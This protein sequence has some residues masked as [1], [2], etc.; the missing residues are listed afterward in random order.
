MKLDSLGSRIRAARKQHNLTQERLATL[1]GISKRTIVY[2]ENDKNSPTIKI[3]EAIANI[4][5]KSPEYFLTGKESADEDPREFPKRKLS[6]KSITSFAPYKLIAERIRVAANLVNQSDSEIAR[7]LGVARQSVQGYKQDDKFPASRIVSFCLKYEVSLDW[8]ASG[9]GPM[10]VGEEEAKL[11]CSSKAFKNE[12]LRKAIENLE[13]IYFNADPV[14][15][16]GPLLGRIE[17]LK[18]LVEKRGI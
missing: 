8:M 7:I 1:L 9:T 18:D 14:N 3:I 15:E 2:Y 12:R 17:A 16:V 5:K 4:C 13:Y 11:V 10:N 6:N